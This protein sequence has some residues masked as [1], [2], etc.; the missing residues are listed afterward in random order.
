[1]ATKHNESH[2]ERKGGGG[3]KD[4]RK[5]GVHFIARQRGQNNHSNFLDINHYISSSAAVTVARA[6]D[7]TLRPLMNIIRRQCERRFFGRQMT[8]ACV[9]ECA[10][11]AHRLP[12]W[13]AL[14]LLLRS[15]A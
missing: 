3:G 15:R 14:L 9:S 2:Q 8:G 5:Q 4:T 13:P 10:D 7:F 12:C 6:L 11:L 1:M